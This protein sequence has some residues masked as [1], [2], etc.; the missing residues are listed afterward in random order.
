ME[1]KLKEN[2]GDGKWARERNSLNKIYVVSFALLM[3]C[4]RLL[5]IK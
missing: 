2:S 5:L 1:K 4:H 3:V